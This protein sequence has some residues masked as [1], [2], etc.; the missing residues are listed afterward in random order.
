MLANLPTVRY[1]AAT[2]LPELKLILVYKYYY[3][4]YW[5]TRKNILRP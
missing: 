5:Y 1:D 4:Y 3:Y 2:N